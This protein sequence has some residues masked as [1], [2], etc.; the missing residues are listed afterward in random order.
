M[1][2][3]TKNVLGWAITLVLWAAALTFLAVAHVEGW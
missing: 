2:E 1:T 3:R